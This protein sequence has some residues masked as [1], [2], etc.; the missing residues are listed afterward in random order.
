MTV[1]PVLLMLAAVADTASLQQRVDSLAVAHRG[2]VALWAK[3]LTTGETLAIN[4][5]TPVKTASVIKL[6]NHD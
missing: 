1:V 5:D 3:N 6:P 4:A 2:R